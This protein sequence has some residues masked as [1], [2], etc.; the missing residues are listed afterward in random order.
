M[1]TRVQTFDTKQLIVTFGTFR[2]TGFAQDIVRALF[3]SARVIDEAGA[4]GETVRVIQNDL[5]AGI[6]LSLQPTSKANDFLTDTG[7]LD[8]LTGLGVLPLVIRDSI[9]GGRD[10]LNAPQAW[11]AT[12]PE[13]VRR[14][15]VEPQNWI[16]RTNNMVMRL[17]GTDQVIA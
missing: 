11:L 7:N 17:R 4:D 5:R 14:K 13:F 12:W 8:L 2:I 10:V 3:D 6:T 9:G 16:L 1:A 15:G